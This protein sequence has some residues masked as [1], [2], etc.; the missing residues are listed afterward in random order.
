MCRRHRHWVQGE[1]SGVRV[2]TTFAFENLH[3]GDAHILTEVV[4]QEVTSVHRELKKR[5]RAIS[6]RVYTKHQGVDH[7]I[8]GSSVADDVDFGFGG[9]F[10]GRRAAL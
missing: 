5:H 8:H 9:L 2:L 4:G 7:G 1:A 3:F 10:K 6:R